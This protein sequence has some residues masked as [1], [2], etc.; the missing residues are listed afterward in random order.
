MRRLSFA[1]LALIFTG[2]AL[3]GCGLFRFEQREA[4]RTQ[5]EEACLAQKLVQPNAYMSRASAIDGP[6]V[7]GMDYPFRVTALAGGAVGLKTKATL[8]CPIIPRTDAW[9]AEVVQPAAML[10]FG[11][12]VVEMR[13]GSYSCR[14]RNN[15]R[16]AK[17]SEH[18]FGNA[19]DVMGFR[20]ADGREITVAKGWRGAPEEQDFLREI[21]VG[22]CRYY[23]TVLGPGSDAFHYDHLHIDLAR[24]DPRGQ[25]HYC[26]PVIKF[27]PRLGDP[28]LASVPMSR[29][30]SS[31]PDLPPA[32]DEGEEGLD[33]SG[34]QA[35]APPF[36][37]VS[38]PL[39]GPRSTSAW[40]S[41]AP[42]P[43]PVP[44]GAPVRLQPELGTGVPIY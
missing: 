4:W 22:A 41:S 42:R 16:G 17:L 35:A 21:F 36:M 39:G 43:S 10:Y 12:P 33:D 38:P 27:T 15:R 14:S 7:C 6:G 32:A 5:A 23:T 18:S 3:T 34:A 9:L 20:F 30:T 37:P 31:L 40:T 25:R 19:I 13:S 28:A 29:P 24:H 1:L 26:K 44:L 8:A 2:L 11:A